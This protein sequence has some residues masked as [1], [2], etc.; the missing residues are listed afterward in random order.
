M[1]APQ[2]N[3]KLTIKFNRDISFPWNISH[4]ALLG[5]FFFFDETKIPYGRA[6]IYCPGLLNSTLPTN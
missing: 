2:V 3:P 6:I 1:A 5:V 4:I